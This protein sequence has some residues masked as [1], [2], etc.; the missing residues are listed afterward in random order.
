MSRSKS[1]GE[2]R[3]GYVVLEGGE[4]CGKDSQLTDL[5]GWLEEQGVRVSLV[6]EPYDDPIVGPFI[7]GLLT[8]ENPNGTFADLDSWQQAMLMNAARRG[9][10]KQVAEYLHNGIWALASRNEDS[11]T[12][13]QGW[14][15]DIPT[16][17]FNEGA[18]ST[19]TAINLAGSA[20]EN[21]H[22]DLVLILDINPEA[23]F[24]RMSDQGRELDVFE[25]RPLEIQRRVR[26]GYLLESSRFRYGGPDV[27]DADRPF[28]QV[29][30]D[31][32]RRVGELAVYKELKQRG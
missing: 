13:Y 12:V 9:I 17:N 18:R 16:E 31:I 21:A 6:R 26:N 28:E 7:Q 14:A 1:E 11:T 19:L 4:G 2:G 24:R 3:G 10:R 22:P 29:S 25:R 5:K 30:Q 15:G 23:A 8:G 20:V 27:I 32:R